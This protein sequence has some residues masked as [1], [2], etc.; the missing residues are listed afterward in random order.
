MICSAHVVT[1]M[2]GYI[3]KQDGNIDWL[4]TAGKPEAEMGEEADMGFH[5]FINSVD[6]IIMGRKTIETISE[7]NLTEEQWP[8]GYLKIFVLSKTLKEPPLNLKDKVEICS[9]DIIELINDL[10]DEGYEKIYVDGGKTIQSFIELKLLN[11]MTIIKAPVILGAGISLFGK[12][13]QDIRLEKLSV[14]AFPNG[15]IQEYFVFN[16]K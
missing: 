14:R 12:T 16:Y 15:F 6:C 1:S 5:E 13:T 10:E 4:D 11:E 9:I 2:D 8:Y 7:M 3:A